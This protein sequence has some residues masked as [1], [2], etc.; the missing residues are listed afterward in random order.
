LI[1]TISQY[2]SLS[3]SLKKDDPMRKA[4][5]EVIDSLKQQLTAQEDENLTNTDRQVPIN[6]SFHQLSVSEIK[7]TD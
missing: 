3:S 5:R 2:E 7:S 6:N 1:S 4:Y